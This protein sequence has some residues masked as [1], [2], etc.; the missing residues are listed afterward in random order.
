MRLG[1][2]PPSCRTPGSELAHGET[3]SRVA[4]A[5]MSFRTRA[6]GAVIALAGAAAIGV[7]AAPAQ[8][9]GERITGKG[10]GA[11]KV[12]ARY[13]KLHR[14]GLVG[15][16]RGGCPLGGPGARVARLRA[17]LV[18]QVELTRKAPRRVRSVRVQ[19]GA[20]ARGV[21]IGDAIA[22]V[23]AAYPAAKVDHSTDETFE[24]T[25]VRVPKRGGGPIVFAVSTR[26][27][28][29]IEIGVPAIPLCE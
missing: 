2:S 26:T 15:R 10:V 4:S 22:D 29:I 24:A 25:M 28:A 20:S 19:G 1:S 16:L 21:G 3:L 27:K 6:L 8:T 7:T 18:G 11:V 23:T 9:G 5:P 12:G 17:P 13:A 14:A